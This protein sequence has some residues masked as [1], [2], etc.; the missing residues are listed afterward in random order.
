VVWCTGFDIPVENVIIEA[1][2]DGKPSGNAYVR[3]SSANEAIHAL[4]NDKKYMGRRYVNLQ[5][6]KTEYAENCAR[7]VR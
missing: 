7:V 6:T 4:K 5:V 2:L 3:F 1:R